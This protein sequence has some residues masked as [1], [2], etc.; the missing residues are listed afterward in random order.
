MKTLAGLILGGMLIGAMV[1]FFAPATLVDA[2]LAQRTQGEVRVA[3]ARG[4][5]WAG[6]GELALS[7]GRLRL[8]V[9]WT[10]DPLSVIHGPIIVALRSRETTVEGSRAVL[11]LA[12]D[13]VVMRN[14]IIAVPASSLAHAAQAL[15][16]EA[17][18]VVTVRAEHVA[19]AATEANGQLVA[20]WR[21]A[22]LALPSIATID[23]GTLTARLAAQGKALTGPVSSQGGQ[24]EVNGTASVGAGHVVIDL[25]ARARPDTPPSLREALKALGPADANGAHALRIDRVSRHRDP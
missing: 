14:V 12:N 3:N 10:T 23:L 9:R 22:R 4:T 18:G 21:N 19:I 20:E 13:R 6:E 24:V 8:P 1:I 2:T 15:P 25:R 17:G 7:R 11:E 5:V 16:Y